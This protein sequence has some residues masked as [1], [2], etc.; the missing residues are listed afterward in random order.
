[1]PKKDYTIGLDIGT[2]SVGWAVIDNEFEVLDVDKKVKI[3]K[4]GK[5]RGK[6][7][8]AKMWGVRL[9]EEGQVAADTRLK[10][11]N[12][13]RL[14]RRH[15]RL[16]Y[17]QEIFANE[18][19][20]IDGNFF[21]R[22]SESFLWLDD[23]QYDAVKY[24]LFRTEM[25]EKAYYK[26]FPTIYHL[27]DY[28]MHHEVDDL[29]LVYLAMHH[30]LKFRGNF[31]YQDKENFDFENIDIEDSLKALFDLYNN[32][33][34][35]LDISF[36][37]EKV[38]QAQEILK[39][40]QW[41]NSKK[42]FELKE[43]FARSD[44]DRQKQVV[45]LFKIIVGNK[46]TFANLFAN[47][48]YKEVEQKDIKLS[49]AT[50]S[51][52]FEKAIS[53][54][55]FNDIEIEIIQKANAVYEATILANI[56]TKP[57]ISQSMV[58]KY[59][60][61]AKDLKVFKHFIKENFDESAFNEMFKDNL[62]GNY[63]AYVKGFDK[64]NKRDYATQEKFYS[65][66]ID[67]LIKRI[68]S[69]YNITL[70]SSGNGYFQNFSDYIEKNLDTLNEIVVTVKYED[71]TEEKF[72]S[73]DIY[74]EILKKIE[75]ETFLPKQ[76]MFKNGAIPFQ[77]HLH[78]L[79]HIIKRQKNKF[80][81]L[82]EKVN[83]SD[84]LYKLETLMKFR[85][86]YYVGPLTPANIGD[87]G[88][89]TSDK[90]RFAW[91]QSTGAN[92][93]PWNFDEVVDK[94]A[95]A[96]EFIQR[97][98][99]F[100]TYLPT[101]KVLPQNS[102]LYQEYT[103]YNELLISG[104]FSE[105][106]EKK[107]FDGQ[108]RQKIVSD[109]FK[110][111]KSVTQ[112]D[113][114]AWLYNNDYTSEEHAKLFGIDTAVK[115]PKFNTKLS[116]Y[117]DLSRIVS[118]DLLDEHLEFFD[119]IVEFQTVFEDNKVLKRQIKILNDK[120][121]NIL[122]S[123]Q[124][125]QLAKKH[126]TGWGRLSRKLLDGIFDNGKTIMDYMRE[127]DYNQNFMSLIEDENK[128]FKSEIEKAQNE[129]IDTSEF[130][131]ENFVAPIAGSPAIKRG[132]WQ[133]LQIVKEISD[134]MTYPPSRVVIEMTRENQTS[135]RSKP[136]LQQLKE[137]RAEFVEELVKLDENQNFDSERVYLYYLQNGKDMYTKET[138]ELSELNQYEVDHIVP[139]TYI[140]DDSI[141][142]K[143][144][145]KRTSNQI[146]GGDVPSSEVVSKMKSYWQLLL[147]ANMISRKKFENLTK[148]KFN[149]RDMNGFINRQLV[150]T[151]QIT[152]NVA[153]ILSNYFGE[154]TDI[155]TPKASLTSQ[156]RKGIVYLNKEDFDE[157]ALQ[158]FLTNGGRIV[159]GKY[160]EVKLH[161]GFYKVREINDYHHAHDAYLNAVVANYLYQKFSEEE[162]KILIYGQ[163]ISKDERKKIGKYATTR[164]G[165]FRQ[166]LTPMVEE[167][168]V[169]FETGEILWQR[170]KVLETITRV[171]SDKQM[172]VVKKVEEQRGEFSKQERLKKGKASVAFKDGWSVEKYGGLSSE[173][174]A[175]AVPVS[176]E[177]GKAKKKVVH[178]LISVTIREKSTFEKDNQAFVESK[179]NP[180][181]ITETGE[182]IKKN[183]AENIKI[184]S[185]AISKYQL[186]EFEDGRKR[187]L[188]SPKESQK[189]N[190][191][192]YTREHMAFLY[193]TNRYDEI[194]YK[195]SFDFVNLNRKSFK[196]ISIFILENSRKYRVHTDKNLEKL[197]DIVDKI[198]IY[199][200]GDLVKLVQGLIQLLSAGTTNLSAYM[201]S[202]KSDKGEIRFGIVT[203]GQHQYTS[204]SDI[205]IFSAT[206]IHQSITG[207]YETRIK[208]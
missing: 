141:E 88:Q 144:L 201:T 11:G 92:I 111:Q 104:Y 131:Y 184:L 125:K 12:R 178:E 185:N 175:F 167:N 182:I 157:K 39:N 94:D 93:T 21:R 110:E 97:M 190:Q 154:T 74:K 96:V 3:V 18:M 69:K 73:G 161:D 187:M 61:H 120:H 95:S 200:T 197:S 13:R 168:W 14:K 36:E 48:D 8:L 112:K 22:L 98:T 135:R 103:V 106:H 109:L 1:M 193:H 38:A 199:D 19:A 55:G 83:E 77:I 176:Y 41:S 137:K 56:L 30:I 162:R 105:N 130:S 142:N 101:E 23:K 7:R 72:G 139:Q 54:N 37:F 146:K 116:T 63:Q 208:L 122:S 203:K 151:R 34:N 24:P 45:E 160:L 165:N 80:S 71:G 119:K 189:G 136:R 76:R 159:D 149:E 27:R 171:M 15:E 207:L 65:F 68:N 62:E 9:F 117:I 181:L 5:T 46:G 147:E 49:D 183:N 166:F 138:L 28:V 179:L 108:T 16:R 43:L 127:A 114:Q 204:A 153:Q 169:N 145:V 192:V 51:E 198:D 191:V 40:K 128:I 170:D 44:K 90:S 195:E 124:I 156:F 129:A 4:N 17:L 58:E 100:D 6:K 85:I 194:K 25:E 155:L 113:M 2:N 172:N 32:V 26:Q 180:M 196:D 174:S 42:A 102:L 78:E 206:L 84:K 140:K 186:F 126:Y 29:R 86:P 107:Y 132:I 60:N 118:P 163:H 59:D 150:E 10:R 82:D 91:M 52:K 205:D 89:K 143:V 121:D 53:E 152:K 158:D 33:D 99:N 188:A 133:S 177:K 31:L 75:L 173:T 115:S 79:N 148:E 81:F 20:K 67:F 202:K 70:K 64:G 57:T 123:E 164:K 66:V 134:I 47:P 35:G 50:A 87:L